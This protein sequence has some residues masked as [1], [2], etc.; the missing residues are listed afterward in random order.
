MNSIQALAALF[1][2]AVLSACVAP[3]PV[4]RSDTGDF[5]Y[6]MS[7]TMDEREMHH[8]L[9]AVSMKNYNGASSDLYVSDAAQQIIA[10]YAK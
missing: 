4:G 2:C 7:A 3:E 8:S 6:S 1:G 9:A 10:Q 5:L